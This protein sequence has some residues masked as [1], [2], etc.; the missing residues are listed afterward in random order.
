MTHFFIEKKPEEIQAF[1]KALVVEAR[2]M[3][4]QSEYPLVVPIQNG[5]EKE[6]RKIMDK[7]PKIVVIITWDKNCDIYQKA[8]L[9]G[10]TE[11]NVPT[12]IILSKNTKG[13]RPGEAPSPQTIHN[14]ILKVSLYRHFQILIFVC[15][16]Q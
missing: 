7:K 13:K 3:G 15:P 10:D 16:S 1:I 4:M 8:K 2:N 9:I 5:F 11:Y 14:I 6:L 12:Q